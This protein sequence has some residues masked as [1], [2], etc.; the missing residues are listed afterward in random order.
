MDGN[1]TPDAPTDDSPDSAENGSEPSV[2]DADEDRDDAPEE[3]TA[4]DVES[5][6]DSASPD[7]LEAAMWEMVGEDDLSGAYWIARSL[8]A[9]GIV[10]PAP[11][12]LFA[13]AQ[14]AKWLSPNSDAYVEDLSEV[15]SGPEIPEKNDAQK[16]LGLAAAL[17]ASVIKPETNLAAWLDAPDNC[18]Q[19]ER[20]VAPIREFKDFGTPARPEDIDGADGIEGLRNAIDKA[21][22]DAREWLEQSLSHSHNYP[23]ATAVFRHL[24][25]DGG[26]LRAMLS[27]VIENFRSGAGDA[28]IRA[29][30]L[31]NDASA[32]NLVDQ[33][34]QRISTGKSSRLEIVGSARN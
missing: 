10:L 21:S 14:G 11:S 23:T 12:R 27:P 9:Q 17:Q 33:T 30:R 22:A 3:E 20:I 8:E 19:L 4:A 1:A 16:L 24:R 31:L 34:H 18:R 5:K 2:D 13:A 29:D 7:K 32:G 25:A 26:E 15:V 28:R 6:D